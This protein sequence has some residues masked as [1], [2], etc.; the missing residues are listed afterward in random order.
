MYSYYCCAHST[1]TATENDVV[2]Y[3]TY[4]ENG[5]SDIIWIYM[6]HDNKQILGINHKNKIKEISF[7]RRLILLIQRFFLKF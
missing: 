6:S 4:M 1:K 2:L 7:Q 3:S 5:C